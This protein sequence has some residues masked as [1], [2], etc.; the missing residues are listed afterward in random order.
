MIHPAPIETSVVTHNPQ[1]F[2]IVIKQDSVM[3]GYGATLYTSS[4]VQAAF[5]RTAENW[6]D[7]VVL[8]DGY[9]SGRAVYKNEVGLERYGYHHSGVS[10]YIEEE[11]LTMISFVRPLGVAKNGRL[12]GL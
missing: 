7:S 9:Y 3:P 10:M 2:E 1:I 11:Y 6:R 4:R 12:Y 8:G 5:L